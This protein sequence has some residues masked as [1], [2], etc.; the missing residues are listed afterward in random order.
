MGRMHMSMK[1]LN[2]IDTIKKVCKKK[3]KVSKAA[4]ILNISE[5]QIKRLKK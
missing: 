5:K 2:R 1:E 3:I 4:K